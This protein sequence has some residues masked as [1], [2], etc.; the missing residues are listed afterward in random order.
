MEGSHKWSNYDTV[1]VFHGN[2]G[3]AVLDAVFKDESGQFK[4]GLAAG[5]GI[6]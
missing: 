6:Y 1:L 4:G 5:L 3:R 2:P